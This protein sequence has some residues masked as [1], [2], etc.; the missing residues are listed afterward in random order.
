MIDFL[1][2]IFGVAALA[3]FFLGAAEGVTQISGVPPLSG[4]QCLA[5]DDSLLLAASRAPEVEGA[6][7]RRDEAIADLRSAESL[8]HPQLSTFGRSGVGDTGLTSSQIDNQIGLRLSQRVMDFGDARLA[9]E[10]ARAT[11]DRRGFDIRDQ[12]MT[13]ATTVALAYLAR[14]EADAMVAVI[15]ERRSYFERQQS[16]VRDLLARGGATRAERAQIAAQ[17]AEAEADMLELIF[18]AERATIRIVEYTGLEL[19]ICGPGDVD[20]TMSDMLRG[21]DTIDDVI[22]HALHHNPL[23]GARRSAIDS[24]EARRERERRSRLPIV[25]VVGVVSYS[26]DDVRED[27]EYRDRVGVDVS[28]PLLSGN[29]IGAG[30]DRAAAQLSQEESGLRSLQRALREEVEITFLRAISLQAQLIRREAVAESQR[31][32]FE[33]IAGEFEFGL[34]TLPE[35]VVARLA[36]EQAMLDV[37]TAQF[38]L[39][40]QKL[41]LM[42]LTARVPLPES[43]RQ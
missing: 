17:L 16:A 8:R 37:V 13:A 31:D 38:S 30:R 2:N 9:R 25:D 4:G 5:F 36:Y 11:L 22:D 3:G 1:R 33:A 27:W 39:L 23:V 34:G 18:Q 7:A 43:S 41:S 15:S 32:Y 42:R 14:L 12:Q 6:W 28:I 10:S 21:L 40:R 26:Y 35:L 19:D 24:L 20:R 29:S